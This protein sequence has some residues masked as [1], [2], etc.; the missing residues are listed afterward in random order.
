MATL[1]STWRESVGDLTLTIATFSDLDDGDTWASGI[2]SVVA[3]W[4]NCTDAAGTQGNEGVDMNLTTASTG[5]FTFYLGEDNR[6][7]MIYVL[8][9]S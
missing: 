1:S 9:S 2:Q 5:T 8:S 7:A 4:G 3:F 6:T